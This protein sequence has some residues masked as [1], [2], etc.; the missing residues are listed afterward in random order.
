[1]PYIASKAMSRHSASRGVGGA[2]TGGIRLFHSGIV[3]FALWVRGAIVHMTVQ[4][5][6]FILMIGFPMVG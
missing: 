1:M 2:E 3:S 5:G 4:F 6:S